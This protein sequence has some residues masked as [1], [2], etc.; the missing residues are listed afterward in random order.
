MRKNSRFFAVVKKSRYKIQQKNLHVVFF[1]NGTR[2]LV[3]KLFSKKIVLYI[4]KS[5]N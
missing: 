4:T 3:E 5:I 2:F 1:F